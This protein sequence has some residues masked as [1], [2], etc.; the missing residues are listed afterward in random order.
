M[1]GAALKV[2][3][4]APN[5]R[6][7]DKTGREVSF[8]DF[9]GKWVVVY[10]YPK[11]NTPGCTLEAQDFTRFSGKFAEREAVVLGISPDSP[12]S[13]EKFCMKFDLTV[14]LLSDPDHA[15]IERYGSWALKKLYGKE[16]H[17][18]VRSTFLVNPDG[19]IAALWR[20]V[21]VN[22]HAEEVLG[23]LDELSL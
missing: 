20:K 3:D 19:K 9:T 7:P 10:L 6:I 21:S 23:K 15:V 18:V 4:I 5:F 11:D 8:T 1:S 13:H 12:A 14:T 22:G 2:G 16:F 17:G